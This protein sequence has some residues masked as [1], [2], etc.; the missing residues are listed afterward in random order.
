[1]D[2]RLG[3]GYI[4]PESNASRQRDTCTDMIPS[5]GE[6]PENLINIAVRLLS[7]DENA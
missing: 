2:S 4:S 6:K 1:M 5:G 7:R 3:A